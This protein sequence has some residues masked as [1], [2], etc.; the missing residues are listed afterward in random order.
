MY[1]VGVLLDSFL[2][3]GN[4]FRIILV[5]IGGIGTIGSYFTDFWKKKK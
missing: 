1:I 5:A 4:A 2:N 3:T